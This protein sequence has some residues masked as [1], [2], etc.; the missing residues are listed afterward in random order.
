MSLLCCC[1]QTVKARSHLSV[2]ELSAIKLQLQRNN[3]LIC[4]TEHTLKRIENEALLRYV[5]QKREAYF[6]SFFA[7]SLGDVGAGSSAPKF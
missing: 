2:A 4:F 7:R 6:L 5:K 1:K 3:A